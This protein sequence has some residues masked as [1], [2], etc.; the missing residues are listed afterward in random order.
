MVFVL[1]S[2]TFYININAKVMCELDNG[3][4]FQHVHVQ[5]MYVAEWNLYKC[6]RFGHAYYTCIMNCNLYL[7]QVQLVLPLS[8]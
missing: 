1:D 3:L 4:L 8:L 6:C 2:A 7:E 5:T